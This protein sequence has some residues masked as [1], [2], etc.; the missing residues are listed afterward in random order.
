MKK[1]SFWARNHKKLSRLIIV[2]SF[3]ILT[4]LGIIT[5]SLLL[6]I[7]VSVSSTA[8]LIFIGGYFIGLIAYPTKSLKG[9]KLTADAF[10]LRQKSCDWILATSSFCMIV[11]FSN[12]PAEIFN[13]TSPVNAAIPVTTAF[14]KDSALKTYKTIDAF[15]ASLKDESGKSM[16]WKEKKKLLKEQVKA[17]N[18]NNDLSN[19]A[20]AG[21][22]ILSVL[23][24]IGLLYG[25]A[26]LSCNISCGGSTG[27]AT[28]VLIGGTAVTV[29]LLIIAIKAI[30]G[31]KNKP[32]K[33]DNPP[34]NPAKTGS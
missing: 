21:L 29:F 2:C 6:D 28:V 15:A 11:Y 17:I 3:I 10:Y 4:V 16:K 23:L 31:K 5:G 27:G 25:V 18:K 19:G 26:A 14:P 12:Q 33:M 13:N 20:K 1:I 32:K 7:G 22:I 30:L 34:E 8:M 9:K 24:A